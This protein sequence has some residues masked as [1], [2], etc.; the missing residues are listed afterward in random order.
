MTGNYWGTPTTWFPPPKARKPPT[1]ES[2]QV[3]MSLAAP[4]WCG[5][6]ATWATP[7]LRPWKE[8][9]HLT[10]PGS[11]SLSSEIALSSLS[12]QAL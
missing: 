6:I 7:V 3:R 2:P 12:R 5:H 4:T 8:K 11:G 1:K 10:L 9:G